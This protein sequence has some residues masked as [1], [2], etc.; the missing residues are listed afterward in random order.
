M[1]QHNIY[2]V[3]PLL[4]LIKQKMS[5][6]FPNDNFVPAKK[7]LATMLIHLYG[8]LHQNVQSLILISSFNCYRP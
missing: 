7:N 8:R 1:L 4:Q 3:M 2:F 6:I 5:I